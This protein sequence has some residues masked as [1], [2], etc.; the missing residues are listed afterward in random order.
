VNQFRGKMKV[1]ADQMQ[2]DRQQ[3]S[4]LERLQYQYAPRLA[5]STLSS[6]V[7]PTTVTMR[8]KDDH[9]SIVIKFDSTKVRFQTKN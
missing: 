6:N 8:L 4:W 1:L 7:L 9:F 3:L 5:A 2:A